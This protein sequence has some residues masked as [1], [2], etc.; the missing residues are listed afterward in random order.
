M[1]LSIR[2]AQAR[3]LVSGKLNDLGSN[4]EQPLPFDSVAEEIMEMWGQQSF[5]P[6]VKKSIT[7]KGLN[8]SKDLLQ[9]VGYDVVVKG[10]NIVRF[11]LLMAPHWQYAEHGRKAGRRPPLKAIEQWITFKGIQVRQSK[12]DSKLSVLQRRRKMARSIQAAIGRKGTIARFN[13][14]GSN[15]LASVAPAQTTIL[16]DLMTKAVGYTVIVSM[17]QVL[18]KGQGR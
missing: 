5:I 8:S 3:L 1:A 17:A 9:S 12:A 14:K 18:R 16:S 11:R 6:A 13:H 7:D 10:N 15:F 4:P 2:D